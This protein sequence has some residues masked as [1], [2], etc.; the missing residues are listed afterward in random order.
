MKNRGLP[1]EPDNP[2]ER[3]LLWLL[4][5]VLF[6]LGG[7]ALLAGNVRL[8][9]ALGA[10]L[11][12][13]GVAYRA[14]RRVRASTLGRWLAT[15]ADVVLAGFAFYLG[16]GTAEEA[17][18]LGG[19]VVATVA[20]RLAMWQALAA[21]TAV[22]LLF[23]WPSIFSWVLQ[24]PSL[25]AG[26]VGG[27][28][29]TWA[30]TW[31]V[32]HFIAVEAQ[33]GEVAHDLSGEL[34]KAHFAEGA[35]EA[36]ATSAEQLRTDDG[37]VLGT[38]QAQ[39]R[40]LG[41][42]FE[43]ST[44]IS[45]SLELDEVLSTVARHVASALQVSSCSISDWDP[46]RNAVTTLV[47]EAVV[48]G[49]AASLSTSDIGKS[50]SLADY[51]ATARVL[52]ERVPL[53][54]QAG[55]PGAD[56]AERLLLEKMGQKSAL[57]MP[58]VTH[59]RVMGLLELY[60]SRRPREFS[61]EDI[62]LCQALANQAA[63]AIDNARL[64]EETDER[65]R[66]RVDELVALQRTMQELNATLER[67]RI[68][69]VVLELAVRTTQATYGG[70]M[71]QDEE[72]GRF[73][74]RTAHGYTSE[75]EGVVDRLLLEPSPAGLLQGVIHGGQPRIVDDAGQE[76]WVERVRGD[77]RSA[78]VVPI[79]YQDVV[80]G[81]ID[82]RHT[83][84]AA[85]DRED[86]R[87]VQALAEQAATAIGNAVRFEEQIRVNNA[88]RQRTEQLDALLAVSQKLRTDVPLEDA[89]EEVAYAIQETVGFNI[90]LI[91]VIEDPQVS[92]P[93]LRRVAAAGLPLE[94]FDEARR[95]RQP[96]ERYERA[97]KEE[98]RQGLCY[99]FPFQK[100]DD[101]AAELHT[102][103]PMAE[104]GEWQQG[105]WH[106][107]DMLLAP[108]RGAGGRLLGHISVDEP[109]D[110]L[111]PSQRTLEVLEIFA[112]QAAI[113][114]ENAHLYADV[115]RRAD[116]LALINEVGQTLTQLVEPNQVLNTVVRAVAL[117]L[118]CET[119]A[120][121]QPD[122]VDGR[123]AAVAS[124]GTDLASLAALRFAPGEGLVG[125]VAAT[126][127]PLMVAD[128]DEESRYV[129]GPVPVGS[130]M[131]VPVGPGRPVMGVLTAGSSRK[132]A[133]READT[134]LL[135]TL[136]DQ[137]AVALKSASLLSSTQQAAL[138]LASLNEIGRRIA[139]QLELQD[140]L[141]TTVNSVHEYLGYERVGI[142]LV[143]ETA[144]ELFVAAANDAFQ[145]ILP[146]DHRQQMGKGL[147]GAVAASGA[148]LVVNDV[149]AEAGSTEVAGW[150][151]LACVSVPIGIG[152]RV[153]GIL[154]V[155]AQQ[156]GSFG[157]EDAAALEIAADQL[158]TSIEN[159]RLFQQAQRRVAE[160]ATVNEIGRAISSALDTGQ[161]AELIYEQVSSLLDTD[162]FSIALYDHDSECIE[163]QFL[164]ERGRRQPAVALKPGH[165]LTGYLIQSGEPL[166]LTRDIGQFVQDLGLEPG[167]ELAK[168]WLG[169]PMISEDQ[170]IGAIAVQSLDREDAFD[171]G[172]LGLL[173]VIAGQ[174]A[175]AYRNA[176]LFQE[177]QQRIEQ[178]DVLN[179]VAQAI[180]S[181]LELDQLLGVVHQQ[182][183]RLVDADSFFIALYD[184][185]NEQI[186]FPFVVDP[187]NRE[188][189]HPR[190]K[191]EGLTGAIIASGKPMLLPAG[192]T[193]R[194]E[195][196]DGVIDTGTCRC[197]LGVPMIAE[198][199]VLGVIAVQDYE[200]E[201]V[202]NE[203]HLNLLSTVAAQAALAVRN[204]QLYRQIVHFS[205]ELEDMV[206]ER[207]RDLG[208]ALQ[209]LT[210]ER[211]RVETL[212]RITSELGA[213]L[214]LERVLQRALRLLADALGL[215]HGTILL[216]DQETGELSL[217]A[218]L[219]EDRRLPRDGKPTRWRL[220]LGLAGWVMEQRKPVLV[221]DISED[222]RW[223]QRPG[224]KL[225]VR[226][227]VAAPL[228]LGGGDILGVLT[229][230]HPKVGYFTEEHLQLVSAATSQI[231]MAV[232]NS[233]L[234]A[235]IIDQA[236]QLGMTL[237]A[238][239]E[240]AA[241]N[242]AV[243]ESIADGVLVL[244][245]N[246]RVLLV[247]PAAEELLG[248]SG[249][250]LQGQHIR[251]MLGM[252]EMAS[253]RELAQL[254]Y[255]E[256]VERLEPGA[257]A[258]LRQE[259]SVRLQAGS[260]VLAATIAPLIVTPGG[261]PGLVAALRDISRE[262]EV[263]RL[264]NEFISTVSHELRTPMTSIK[265]YTDL[266][267]LGMAGGL[268]D[269]QRD[270][271]RIIKSNADRLTALVTD[272]LDISRIETGRMRLTIEALDL[273]QIIGQ[274]IVAF[275]EQYREKNLTLNWEEPKDLPP[276]RGDAAR[277]TQV[278]SNLMANAWQYTPQDGSVTIQVREQDGFL[279]VDIADSGIGIAAD[280][281]GRIFD[282]FYRADHP[283]VQEAAGTGLGLSIVR[284]FVEMLGGEIWVTS[285]LGVGSTFSFTMPLMSTD[286]PEPIPDLLGAQLVQGST[287]RPKILVVEDDR[288]LAVLLRRQLESEGYQVLLA[289][290]GEDALWLAREAK[291]QLITLDV[292]L[293]DIDGFAVLER[294][295]QN[296]L[297]SGIPVVIVSV[298][299]ETEKGYALGAV[300]YVVKPFEE[301]QLLRVV[302]EAFQHLE[303]E[304]PERLVVAE[305]DAEGRSFM[306]KALGLHGY[307]V[308]TASNG[309]EAL[310]QVEECQPDLIL[311]DV[312]MPVMDGYEV[313]RRL[314][315][316][317][318]T[319]VIPVI[320]IT[321]R[322]IDRER[323][324]VQILGT[325]VARYLRKPLSVEI[326]IR[327]IKKA[328]SARPAG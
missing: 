225:N 252:G 201:Y 302:K 48:A 23:S 310:A 321:S 68:L 55:D 205:S 94:V 164:V 236:D 148:T 76:T 66:A 271:L 151:S 83:E 269:A 152:E 127:Q 31:G 60:E 30:V 285:E 196:L 293:P 183:T 122:A 328:I 38:Q 284:M 120:V 40:E 149:R 311:L 186:T 219:D 220:G 266:L 322:P 260:Q 98:Y 42:L 5:T 21:N 155:E 178:L 216:F 95:I 101:W 244:D 300:D 267:F 318:A 218:T 104:T 245:H 290:T 161:L 61:A 117:L 226:S 29:L 251:H 286:L 106:P 4:R 305:D 43:T 24:G 250:A 3:V 312:E 58:L 280:D 228:S 278:L 177:R 246:G 97:L 11:V 264:K 173:T 87:F 20:A 150:G 303:K 325:R 237:Q 145:A 181:T 34:E 67:D 229:L 142:F 233:D 85:F 72:T 253:Q 203:E 207:T 73:A 273:G 32:H 13:H 209:D 239:Q 140:M 194:Y 184:D 169:V 143:D 162:N 248:F 197:W 279:Q 283:V 92:R 265:G 235:F 247:N 192:A 90:V 306:E 299:T 319:R 1:T 166:L 71:L 126:G 91:S 313:V 198:D 174:A 128:T 16:G 191:G 125:A 160:L 288:D 136:A 217:R 275:Q 210:V 44:A 153:I 113:A 315:S 326:L 292:M 100:Q 317:E 291:P 241:R 187:E 139:S 63:V 301:E 137:L 304:R 102:M 185:E 118:R 41:I 138:R 211:D 12:L 243:L 70:V 272:I 206:E 204:A 163:I 28:V 296:P 190:A 10:I 129:S 36:W 135:T 37:A 96:L 88:L 22:W 282:R 261:A 78:L 14:L 33:P 193:T 165:E 259:G 214:E 297:T 69:E 274:V 189:W 7:T 314:Q 309:E 52:R 18:L 254:L 93:L 270:F 144:S 240:E 276:I 242:Q 171:A 8:G 208:E 234:Y 157:E 110:G 51:P 53:M 307:Q 277:V 99:F 80:V 15:V 17:I 79:L 132:H 146:I 50:Y 39:L 115:H 45:S 159:A 54:I 268:T 222:S 238:Q 156:Q 176:S 64:Y 35:T 167:D 114:V 121:F 74:L 25:I 81:L 124:H 262:A 231:A 287:R 223:V 103:V 130:M 215:E 294:L 199:K 188:D 154:Q 170:V 105:Q 111:R 47:A 257:Q 65:L 168:S 62:R 213:S 298:L 109:R 224:K 255:S 227:V 195:A 2:I 212:Y 289:G 112:N 327:E 123:L 316:D 323:D 57:L 75:E 258:A 26:P 180:T 49:Q 295:K 324:R 172:H 89:L 56:L 116:N 107:R 141:E 82:L 175:V 108:L 230:G 179:D 59:D 221:D 308:W 200:R 232:N 19:C 84:V 46:A 131:L 263:E 249:L 202:Y 133:F 9:L 134:L 147:I 158:A 256:L 86:Q 281:L 320:L 27:L 182:V 6:V 77:T 119:S